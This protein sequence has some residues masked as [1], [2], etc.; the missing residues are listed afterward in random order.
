MQS[1]ARHSSPWMRAFCISILIRFGSVIVEG[2]AAMV[3]PVI[4]K[5]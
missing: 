5:E 1:L 3:T 2:S 4:G